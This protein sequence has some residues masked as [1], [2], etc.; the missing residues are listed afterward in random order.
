MEKD[1]YWIWPCDKCDILLN[2]QY[3]LHLIRQYYCL[4]LRCSWSIACRHCPITPSFP[5]WHLASVDWAKTTTI[6]DEKHL[7]SGIWCILYQMFD[8]MHI[9]ICLG[10]VLAICRCRACQYRKHNANLKY[11]L[12]CHHMSAMASEIM[13][14]LTVCST[15]YSG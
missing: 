8:S 5:T 12:H 2:L 6:Q 13:G 1:L 9:M 4:S 15:G 11:S 10:Q 7:I 3:K 14:N